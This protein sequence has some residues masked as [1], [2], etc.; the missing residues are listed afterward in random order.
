AVLRATLKDRY[1]SYRVGI[2]SGFLTPNEARALED[3]PPL[4][5]G[6]TFGD[7]YGGSSGGELTP[8]QLAA[9]LQKIYLAVGKVISAEEAR[10]LL[11]RAGADL[12]G[13][14]PDGSTP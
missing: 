14:G 10:Q 9:A 7:A 12:V 5:G 6:D 4:E 2:I 11:N 13:P 8:M 3:L 1:A